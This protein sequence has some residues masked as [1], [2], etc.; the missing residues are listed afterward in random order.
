MRGLRLAYS[1]EKLRIQGIPFSAMM[2]KAM[3]SWVRTGDPCQVESRFSQMDGVS[4][5]GV[6]LMK[7]Q[8]GLFRESESRMCHWGKRGDKASP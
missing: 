7:R 6:E 3:G 8:V 2:L 1:N 5:A 4:G